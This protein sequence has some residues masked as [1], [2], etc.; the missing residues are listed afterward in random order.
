VGGFSAVGFF[1][2]RFLHNMLNVPVGLINDAWGGSAA[3]AWVNRGELEKDPR[4]KLL[5]EN[6]KKNEA[7]LTSPAAK[8]KYDADLANWQKQAAEAKKAGKPFTARAPAAPDAWL[9]G[10][11][12]PGNIYNG[13][14]LP[15]IGY[16]IK[17][18]IWYQGES[19]AGRAY[20]YA[21]LFPFMIQNWRNE[22]KQGD[23]PFYWVQLA[24]FLNEKDQPS[25]SAWAELREAQTMTMKRLPK[26]ASALPFTMR[27]MSSGYSSGL[28]SRSASC[29]MMMSP[30]ASR[31]PRRTAAPFP[32]FWS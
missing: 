7:Y 16:G 2:G 5:M 14:L 3:E 13:A 11:A 12:R 32:M 6:T 22:W 18:V 30:S 15:T 26:T 24:D 4:F 1:Y 20:E 28:Y 31:I 23:F 29:T 21:S 19:N 9:R 17:G 10:N 25:E 27:S 8:T